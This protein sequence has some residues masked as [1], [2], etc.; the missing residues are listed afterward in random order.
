MRLRAAL[1]AAALAAGLLGVPAAAGAAEAATT[2]AAACKYRRVAQH[3]ECVTPG[4]YCPVAA[5]GK[6]GI[7]KI[8]NKRYRCTQYSNGR[9]RWKRA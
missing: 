8:T 2:A 3:W 6:L 9:W 1:S 5:H 4:A 7:A